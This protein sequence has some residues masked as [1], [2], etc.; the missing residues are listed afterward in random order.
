MALDLGT[1]P[2]RRRP[3]MACAIGKLE[4]ARG[5]ELADEVFAAMTARDDNDDYTWS[6]LV[7]CARL[8]AQA[9][10]ILISEQVIKKHRR[11]ACLCCREAGRLT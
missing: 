6:E 11:G 2:P 5:T 1:P 4:H 8:A 10:P 9:P 3:G 7:L